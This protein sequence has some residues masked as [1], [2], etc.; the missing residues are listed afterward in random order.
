MVPGSEQT[1]V[2]IVNYHEILGRICKNLKVALYQIVAIVMDK[3]FTRRF[4]LKIYYI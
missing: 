2:E 3:L 1:N 4:L